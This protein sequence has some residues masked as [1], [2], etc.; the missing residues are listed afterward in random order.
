MIN[1]KGVPMDKIHE[2]IQFFKRRKNQIIFKKREKTVTPI[3]NIHDRNEFLFI[4][5]TQ[6]KPVNP[7][8][9]N[10]ISTLLIEAL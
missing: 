2:I 10:Y 4:Y 8:P 5:H 1:E 7:S 3:V 6:E 9:V